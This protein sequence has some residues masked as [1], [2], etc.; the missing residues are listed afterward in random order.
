MTP[1]Q[2]KRWLLCS[3][4]AATLSAASAAHAGKVEF[5]D[6]IGTGAQILVEAKH[7]YLAFG[8]ILYDRANTFMS[9]A[10]YTQDYVHFAPLNTHKGRNPNNNMGVALI[11]AVHQNQGLELLKCL[12]SA[13]GS[14]DNAVSLLPPHTAVMAKDGERSPLCKR[15]PNSPF[16]RRLEH[17]RKI[18]Q[19]KNMIEHWQ[20]SLTAMQQ[21]ET[22]SQ[23]SDSLASRISSADHN[24]SIRLPR[25]PGLLFW[26]NAHQSVEQREQQ[27]QAVAQLREESQILA[28][29]IAA[30][31][32][33]IRYATLRSRDDVGQHL[34]A[35]DPKRQQTKRLKEDT[36][37]VLQ[38]NMQADAL[39]L[40]YANQ[41]KL[42]DPLAEAHLAIARLQDAS[43]SGEKNQRKES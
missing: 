4:C 28:Q 35:Q 2:V 6:E 14:S 32:Q 17:H 36:Q 24:T 5:F 19:S 15:F 40:L 9:Q 1:H 37:L 30:I 29:R 27:V 41:P 20:D 42:A 18:Q 34:A 43:V 22:L 21:R 12:L 33:Q 7:R 26:N 39:A 31:S 8:D 13:G 16:A 11:R 25:V 3:L 38:T 10:A 23:A